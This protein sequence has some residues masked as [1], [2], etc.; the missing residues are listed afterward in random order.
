MEERFLKK[1]KNPI[2]DNT[3]KI[4]EPNVFKN[5]VPIGS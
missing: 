2:T 5:S 3:I 4:L 1:Y